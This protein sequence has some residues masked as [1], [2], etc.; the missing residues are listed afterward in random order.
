MKWWWPFEQKEK[1]APKRARNYSG[2]QFNR[3]TTDWIAM[4]TSADTEVRSSVRA[5]R[6]RSRQLGRDNDYVKGVFRDLVTNVIGQGVRLQSQIEKARGGLDDKL[7]KQVQTIF[8]R[9]KKAE[10]CHTAGKLSFNEIEK[11]VTRSVVESGEVFIRR[12]YQKFGDSKIPLGLEILEADMVDDYYNGMAEKTGNTIRMG[13][14]FDKWGRP[15]AY[16]VLPNH[17]GDYQFGAID[18]SLATLERIRVPA[19]EIIHL[20]VTERPGQSRGVPWLASALIRM[21]HM[22]GYEEA[23]VISARAT[24]SLMGFIMTPEA[25]LTGDDVQDGDQVTDFEP[26][27]WKK[28]NPGE[29]AVVPDLHRPSGQFDPFMRVMLRGIATAM[30]V[31]YE[32][33]SSDYSQTNY[34]SARQ[35]LVS[36]RDCFKTI[37]V[38]IIEKFHQPVF[39]SWLDMAVLAG[40]INIPK[41]DLLPDDYYESVKWYPRTWQW[42]DPLKDMQANAL[43]VESGF[44]TRSDVIAEMGGDYDD[45]INQR[46]KEV[47]I[48]KAAGLNFSANLPGSASPPEDGGDQN[49][50]PSTSAN[51]SN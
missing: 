30:G 13:I 10:R 27:V 6:S 33:V 1:K 38:W 34:S 36:V 40:E 44:K 37:Q 18:P 49:A 46:K 32:T 50:S 51:A 5:L 2:A 22:Q 14:E 21:R 31:T 12:I 19:D 29:Q 9:W 16:Y 48:E 7:N 17:P 35:A 15:V 8:C 26:G 47:E 41:Y 39:N 24:A 3:L 25:E 23:E 4:Y 43:A 11:L 42:I 28:L 45:F 20:F